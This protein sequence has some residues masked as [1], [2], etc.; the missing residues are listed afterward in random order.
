MVLMEELTGQPCP[1]CGKKTCTL[2]EEE[3]DIPYFGKTFL[4]SMECQSCNFKQSDLEAEEAKE[5]AKYTVE[6]SSPD[7]MSIRIVKSAQ[8]TVKWP[9]LRVSID[10]GLAAQGAVTN[11]E[12]MLNDIY[13]IVEAQRENEDDAAARK[14]AFKL[15]QKILDIKEG[16]QTTKLTI[17]DPTGNSMIVSDKAEKKKL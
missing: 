17:E 7:D 1:A 11:I 16:K 9:N 10:P 13:K 6:I 5:P 14:K 8:A 2:R 3:L 15:M 12:K 4:F